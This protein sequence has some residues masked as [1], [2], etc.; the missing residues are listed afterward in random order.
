MDSARKKYGWSGWPCP[1][2]GRMVWPVLGVTFVKDGAGYR[3]RCV[4]CDPVAAS[5]GK[6]DQG[7]ER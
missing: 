7:G 6:R 2:C 4:Y 5:S 3:Q 1:R